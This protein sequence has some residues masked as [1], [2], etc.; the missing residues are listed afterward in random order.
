MI[1]YIHELLRHI[2]AYSEPCVTLTYLKLWYIQNLTYSKSEA[3]WKPGQTSTMKCFRKIVNGYNYFHKLKSF[4]VN[5]FF[6]RTCNLTKSNLTW[7]TLLKKLPFGIFQGFCFKVLGNFF[8]RTPPRILTVYRLC[9]L[10]LNNPEL[11]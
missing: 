9:T 3:Y 10:F 5:E 6:F 7:L 1:R 2:Q 4:S 11:C 8:H